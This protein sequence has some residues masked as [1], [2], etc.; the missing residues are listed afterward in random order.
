MK[1]AM[2]DKYFDVTGWLVKFSKSVPKP[3]LGFLLEI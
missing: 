3:V 2:G 1:K